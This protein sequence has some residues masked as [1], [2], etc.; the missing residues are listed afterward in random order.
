MTKEVVVQ[1]SPKDADIHA[2]VDTKKLVFDLTG[3]ARVGVEPGTHVLVYFLVAEP[4]TK[5]KM[6]IQ[7]PPEAVFSREHRVP[8]D[9]VTVGTKKFPV[10]M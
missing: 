4:G 2:Q 6:E 1:R 10:N 3:T 7:A 5:F 8:S 9:G